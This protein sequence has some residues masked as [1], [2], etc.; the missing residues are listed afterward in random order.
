MRGL[1]ILGARLVPTI[2]N[3]EWGFWSKSVTTGKWTKL[4]GEGYGQQDAMDVLT[5]FF[6]GKLSPSAGAIRDV[7][8]GEKF[9]GKKPTVINTTLGLITPISAQTLIE[10]LKKGSDDLLLVMLAEAFGISVTNYTFRGTGK[11]WED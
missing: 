6:A 1:V 10:E 8:K 3:G 7:W 5:N 2:H 9:S 11:K 4:G